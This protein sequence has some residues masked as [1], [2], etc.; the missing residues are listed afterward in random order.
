ML[1]S[2]QYVVVAN[3]I[4]YTYIVQPWQGLNSSTSKYEYLYTVQPYQRLNSM[5]IAQMNTC[6]MYIVQPTRG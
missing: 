5:V 6:T 3:T 4:T 2:K 1:N